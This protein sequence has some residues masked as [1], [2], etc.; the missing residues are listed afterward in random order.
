[1]ENKVDDHSREPKDPKDN[2]EKDTDPAD[3]E[4]VKN[5]HKYC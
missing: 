1:M 4:P 3:Q 2:P 5:P